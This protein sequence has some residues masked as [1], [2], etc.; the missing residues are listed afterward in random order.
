MQKAGPFSFPEKG[1]AWP[2]VTTVLQ[3]CLGNK[4]SNPAHQSS[5]A[6]RDSSSQRSH[7]SC[8]TEIEP[9]P[10]EVE[11]HTAIA[12]ATITQT[13]KGLSELA[14]RAMP[15][16]ISSMFLRAFHYIIGRVPSKSWA[17]EK[18]KG[19]SLQCKIYMARQLKICSPLIHLL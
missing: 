16:S 14:P 13:P 6:I 2:R 18:R 12:C 9:I 19:L 4:W 7:C 1:K 11:I 3:Q 5:I 15:D 8:W 10:E 17:L